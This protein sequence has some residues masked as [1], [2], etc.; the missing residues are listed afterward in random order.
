M[1]STHTA[2][3]PLTHLYLSANRVHILP[4]MKGCYLISYRQLCDDGFAVKFNTKN[5][6]LRKLNDFPTGYRDAT[7]GLYLIGFYKP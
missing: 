5:V 2:Y 3:L 1:R 7:T 4:V 6:F